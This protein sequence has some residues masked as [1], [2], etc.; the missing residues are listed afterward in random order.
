MTVHARAIDRLVSVVDRFHQIPRPRLD[1]SC[2]RWNDYEHGGYRSGSG[3]GDT[4][5][6]KGE[7]SDLGDTLAA[8]W[9]DN[10][11]IIHEAAD[12]VDSLT[13]DLA[14]LADI[15]EI[16]CVTEAGEP[17][18]RISLP[19]GAGS[20]AACQIWCKGT[21]D[22]RLVSGLCPTHY[23]GLRRARATGEDRHDYINR[24][25]H[26]LDDDENAA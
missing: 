17:R 6:S 5:S 24:I 7:V 23:E 11:P 18:E 4:R 26:S 13:T 21:R 1:L 25:R 8:M 2:S 16:T 22:D 19:A 20:C 14:R 12:L 3:Q 10:V 9:I 15:I